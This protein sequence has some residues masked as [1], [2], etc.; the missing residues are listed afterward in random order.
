MY[1]T[2]ITLL[3]IP[4]IVILFAQCSVTAQ[5]QQKVA[6]IGFLTP[7]FEP[8]ELGIAFQKELRDIGYVEGKN[9]HIEYRGAA[10]KVDRLEALAG[11]LVGL[12]VAAI[13]AI[14]TAATLAAKSR[15]K[16]IPIIMVGA[17]DPVESGLIS[18]FARPS[19]NVTG[20]SLPLGE[21]GAKQLELLKEMTPGVTRVAALWNPSYPAA[22]ISFRAVAAA[23]RSLGLQLL[24]VEVRQSNEFETAFSVMV[25]DGAR[26]LVLVPDPMI[27]SN[28]GYIAMLA[29]RNHLPS[30]SGLREFTQ[31]GGLLAYGPVLNDM[32]KRAASYV[33]KVL[34]GAKAADLPVEQPTRF[35]LMVNRRTANLLNLSI[36]TSIIVRA[37]EWIE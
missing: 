19:G 36:P 7:D 11:D 14:D 32:S 17:G 27:T 25:K 2:K 10:G 26:A 28:F 21:I 16:D 13:V 8:S 18:G 6:K 23:A 33:S 30:I 5:P 37:E 29:A 9:I 34:N 4:I 24:S 35:H 3:I 15:T 31:Y 1:K 12:D 20:L 22:I